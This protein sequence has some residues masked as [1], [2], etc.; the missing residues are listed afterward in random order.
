MKDQVELLNKIVPSEHIYWTL[1]K[2]VI[3]QL[4]SSDCM[5]LNDKTIDGI[6]LCGYT[7]QRRIFFEYLKHSGQEILWNLKNNYWPTILNSYNS[8]KFTIGITMPCGCT[9]GKQCR[10]MKG[11]RD[12]IGPLLNSLLI[13]DD[14]SD[15]MDIGN[16][17][18]PTYEYNNP[19]SYIEITKKFS[20]DK[21]RKH[22]ID[23]QQQWIIENSMD[24]QLERI[25]LK[26][27]II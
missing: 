27:N 14:Y 21:I 23:Q 26:H 10:S 6:C 1:S 15:I 8:S 24:V 20:D 25:F 3:D 17:I 9:N 7:E 19:E 2:W 22:T 5:R 11:M 4:L 12:Y 13:C 16:D 18:I